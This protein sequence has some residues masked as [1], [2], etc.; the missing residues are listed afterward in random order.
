MKPPAGKWSDTL[1]HLR[2]YKWV[3]L[4]PTVATAMIYGDYSKTQRFKAEH[5]EVFKE[6]N[7]TSSVG[8][9]WLFKK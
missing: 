4:F 6:L 7:S 3:I 9:A 1:K 5:P 8:G 2:R